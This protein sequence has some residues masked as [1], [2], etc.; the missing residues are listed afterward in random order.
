MNLGGPTRQVE[1][2]LSDL[3]AENARLQDGYDG[4]KYQYDE[5][6][7]ELRRLQVY[8]KAL[9]EEGMQASLY[10]RL[11]HECDRLLAEVGRQDRENRRQR[12]SIRAAIVQHQYD[13]GQ[14]ECQRR[15]ADDVVSLRAELEAVR[16]VLNMDDPRLLSAAQ[17]IV[18]LLRERAD[19]IEGRLSE[20][21]EECEGVGVDPSYLFSMFSQDD[22]G[23]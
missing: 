16:F 20:I 10:V 23:G 5:Q 9:D 3:R 21:V 8:I 15:A 13:A 6:H 19:A 2:I 22:D 11:S 7:D 17:I 14:V 1:Q 4:L 12:T 18:D